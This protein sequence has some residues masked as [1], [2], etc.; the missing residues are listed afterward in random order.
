MCEKLRCWQ[1]K[2]NNNNELLGTNVVFGSLAEGALQKK[3]MKTFLKQLS[4]ELIIIN[5]HAPRNLASN[6]I[7]HVWNACNE[8]TPPA[9]RTEIKQ[10]PLSIGPDFEFRSAV[11]K[12]EFSL[13]KI[14]KNRRC[15]RR[16][17]WLQS[18]LAKRIKIPSMLVW[19]SCECLGT[20]SQTSEVRRQP[21]WWQWSTSKQFDRYVICIICEYDYTCARIDRKWNTPTIYDE[22]RPKYGISWRK[23][24]HPFFAGWFIC[25]LT[26]AK[27]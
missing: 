9:R 14:F 20:A 18:L 21:R 17:L 3:E 25:V 8:R 22:I 11:V 12:S 15:R 4:W 26:T 7:G 16:C 6:H 23:V 24:Y 10:K 5:T 2:K 13:N 19:I 27:L 1:H